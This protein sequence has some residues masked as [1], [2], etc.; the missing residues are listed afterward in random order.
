MMCDRSI[1]YFGS[2]LAE[3]ES[4]IKMDSTYCFGRVVRHLPP[5]VLFSSFLYLNIFMVRPI[6]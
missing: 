2:S 1:K 5:T 3:M 6:L 4:G